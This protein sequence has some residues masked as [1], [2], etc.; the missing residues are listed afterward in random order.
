MYFCADIKKNNVFLCRDKEGARVRL[1]VYPS[2]RPFS[3]AGNPLKISPLSSSYIHSKT[4]YSVH[5]VFS[6]PA[7][8]RGV[9]FKKEQ[10]LSETFSLTLSLSL[11][12]SLSGYDVTKTRPECHLVGAFTLSTGSPLQQLLR[13]RNLRHFSAVSALFARQWTDFWVNCVISG[14]GQRALLAFGKFLVKAEISKW[15]LPHRGAAVI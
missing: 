12:L 6:R 10:Q 1:Q 2:C 7:N 14:A 13:I 11:S 15:Q 3:R 9:L 4:S 5:Y 8:E